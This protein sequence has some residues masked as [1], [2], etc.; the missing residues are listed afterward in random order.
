MRHLLRINLLKKFQ[1]LS[2]KLWTASLWNHRPMF[3]QQKK[4]VQQEKTSTEEEQ[5]FSSITIATTSE[6]PSPRDKSKKVHLD[7]AELRSSPVP[8]ATVAHNDRKQQK[9]Q[10]GGKIVDSPHQQG[11]AVREDQSSK[12]HF[13]TVEDNVLVNE[14]PSFSTVTMVTPPHCE[15]PSHDQGLHLENVYPISNSVVMVTSPAVESSQQESKVY[16]IAMEILPLFQPPVHKEFQPRMQK[17]TATGVPMVMVESSLSSLQ[18]DREGKSFEEVPEPLFKAV[19]S[20]PVESQINVLSTEKECS[21][22][23]EPFSTC[24]VT[25]LSPSPQSVTEHQVPVNQAATMAASGLTQN[26]LTI[27]DENDKEMRTS[28][29]NFTS[30]ASIAATPVIEARE[31]RSNVYVVAMTTTPF[32]QSLSVSKNFVPKARKTSLVTMVTEPS[33]FLL[34]SDHSVRE[35]ESCEEVPEPL[36]LD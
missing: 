34:R 2:S 29:A 30:F 20:L 11:M 12:E 3:S 23:K 24:D 19:D 26:S 32:Q 5:T 21:E 16:V 4:N 35:D 7:D 1:N 25:T 27:T 15:E 6:E 8:M 13:H 31:T 17:S 9:F 28:N 33:P 14:K 10:D 18:N 36:Q 22:E